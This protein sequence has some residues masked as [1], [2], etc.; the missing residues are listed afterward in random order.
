VTA[1]PKIKRKTQKKPAWAESVGPYGHRI[2]VFE[3]INSGILY[4][5]M[6]DPSRAGAYRSISLRHRDKELEIKWAHEQV[7]KWMNKE[8]DMRNQKP[9]AAFVLCL[10]LEHQTPTKVESERAADARRAEMFTRVLGAQKDLSLLSLRDWQF[11]C[12]AR[13]T[14]QINA[15]GLRVDAADRETVRDG[16]VSADLGFLLMVLNWASRWRSADGRYLMSENPARGYPLPTER[17]PR[18][19]VV[20]EDRFQRVRKVAATV[21]MVRG[22]G[23]AKEITPTYLPELLDLANGTGRRISAILALRYQDLRLSEGP[24][25]SIQWPAATDKA[26]K[27]SL[28]PLNADARDALNRV[29]AVRPGIGAAFLFPAIND[30]RRSVSPEVASAW[31]IKA[32]QLAGVPKHDGSLWHAYRRKWATERKF[33]PA[34]DVAAAGGWS[35]QSTLTNIYQQAD[36]ATMYRVVSEPSKLRETASRR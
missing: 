22:F 8:E 9:T 5:E 36:Q 23:R 10:Y 4:G 18:R 16:T 33:L 13:R 29:L 20:S 19:P 1:T 11:F 12:E 17:N 31:L 21:T 24:H 6:R 27:T 32:E 25:G 3:D 34:A 2:R 26:K 15:R 14:G 30:A 28:V 7:A 35:D